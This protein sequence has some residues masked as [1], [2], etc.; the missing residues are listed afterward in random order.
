M[1]RNKFEMFWCFLFFFSSSSCLVNTEEATDKSSK[2]YLIEF[3][4]S[5][6]SCYNV[7]EIIYI[8]CLVLCHHLVL[9]KEDIRE[10]WSRFFIY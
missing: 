3:H 8:I 2:T 9:L 7:N 6:N 5:K 10:E 4:N 1:K